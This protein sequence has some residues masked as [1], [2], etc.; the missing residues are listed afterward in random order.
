M[1]LDALTTF[2]YANGTPQS[3]VGAAGAAI[4]LGQPIDLLGQGVGTIPQNIIGNTSVFGV[5]P[6]IGRIR[7]EIQINIGTGFTTGN[8][9]TG[10]FALQ[11]AADQGAAGNYQP[12]T[13]Y[14]SSE[15]QAH[16]VSVLTPGQIIRLDVTPAPP[17]V[18]TPRYVRLI[19]YPPAG[20]N[21]SA[22]TVSAAFMTMA[23]DDQANRQAASNYTVA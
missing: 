6:G 9:A 4:P 15:T 21:F 20:E 14:T 10:T 11:Y 12:A 17:E 22:G 18:L 5:D 16:A 8:A 13:W 7:P 1:Q 19:C 2:V 3:V 23:R